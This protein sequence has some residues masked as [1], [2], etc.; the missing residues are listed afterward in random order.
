MDKYLNKDFLGEF[1]FGLWSWVEQWVLDYAT[2]GQAVI[3][4]IVSWGAQGLAKAL[5]VHIEK[6]LEQYPN[7]KAPEKHIRPLYI[8]LIA[9]TFIVISFLIG[10]AA[11]LP[12]YFLDIASS[13]LTA[14]II[15]R[16]ASSF[17]GNKPLG[18]LI[19][20]SAWS[21]AALDILNLMEP[22]RKQLDDAA[23]SIGD[24]KYT[25]LSIIW[26]FAS[27]F[28]FIWGALFAAK[29]IEGRI[30]KVEAINPSA[31][32]LLTKSVKILLVS[33]AFLMALNNTGIDLTALAVFG[34]AVGVGVGF[35][36]QKVVSNFISGVILL[37]DRSIKPGD[38]IEVQGAYG[39]INSL[40]ARYT[41]VITRDGTE[42]LIPN[43]DMITQ[44]VINWSHSHTNVRRHIPISVSYGSDLN[45]VIKIMNEAAN[46]HSRTLKTPPIRTLIKGFGDNGIDMELRF[47]IADPHNGVSNIA[48]DIMMT[49]W[50]KF[51]EECI[52]FPFPQRVIHMA[53]GG[54]SLSD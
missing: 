45:R 47:W 31:R 54:K 19:A 48:S 34:G 17:I 21:Y 36:L 22:I 18:R 23:F 26:G 14:W 32:V 46:E 3:I 41:S 8:P 2:L 10:G 53:D 29:L 51:N 39:S 42:F 24:T 13:L 16:L 40:A 52:E 6:P 33:M 44:P 49:I 15:I 27:F 11:Q 38:V 7:L 30:R 25:L 28:I 37:L 4:L 12:V 50:N 1:F 43:E 35:G 9:L 20:I 5:I